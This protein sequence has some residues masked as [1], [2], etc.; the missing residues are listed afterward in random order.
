MLKYFRAVNQNDVT[1]VLYVSGTA[2]GDTSE[3]VAQRLNLDK[4]GYVL[5]ECTKEEFETMTQ[6]VNDFIINVGQTKDNLNPF[7]SAHTEEEA[8]LLAKKYCEDWK[9]VE[10]VYMPCDNVDVNEIIYCRYS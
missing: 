9:C 4:Y 2:S 3:E 6:E 7:S 5:V 8:V 1:D 10:V